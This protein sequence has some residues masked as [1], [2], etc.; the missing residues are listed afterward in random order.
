MTNKE[1]EE[2]H[3]LTDRIAKSLDMIKDFEIFAY[4]NTTGKIII[5]Y[6]DD[7]YYTLHVTPTK[8]DDKWLERLNKE[9]TSG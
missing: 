7:K 4:Q 3:N 5:H 9:E 8:M 2:R 6:K 1:E